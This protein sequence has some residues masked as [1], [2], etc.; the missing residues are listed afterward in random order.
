M[1]AT[2]FRSALVLG[3]LSAIGPFSIDMYLP[4][5]PEIG[6]SLG[7]SETAVQLTITLYLLAFGVSQFLWGPLADAFGRKPPLVAGILLFIVGSVGCAFATDLDWLLAGRVVQ[8]IGAASVGVVP[9][10]VARDRF[11]GVEATKLLAMMMLVIAVSPMLAPLAGSVALLSGSWRLIFALLVAVGIMSLLV[12]VLALPETLGVRDRVPV[13]LRSMAAG[14]RVLL[15]D[16]VF[17]SLS[18]VSAFGFA[19]FF[20]FIAAAAFVYTTHF[21]LSQTGFSLA[22]A[23]N[24]LGFFAASQLS[25]AATQRFGV[26]AMVRWP[27]VAFAVVTLLLLALVAAGLG[28]LP[29][30]M[31]LLFCA[32]AAL[33]LVMPVAFVMAIEEHG[34][35]AGLASSLAG[36]IQMVTG[37]LVVTLMAP[38]FDNTP[39]PMV[40]AIALCGTLAAAIGLL[41]FRRVPAA[42]DAPRGEP[43]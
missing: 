31:A 27:L 35:I 41:A 32:N 17:M 29:V 37:S 34:E 21:G 2:L 42:A 4:A 26:M 40:A 33:G 30:I 39:L 9:R 25:A 5:M 38:F 15:A 11:T 13:N 24:A 16:P 28:S 36:T 12:T 8:G 7:A 18:F 19:S 3:L 23:V 22:F 1:H 14:C 43:A 10:A 6:A 20:V